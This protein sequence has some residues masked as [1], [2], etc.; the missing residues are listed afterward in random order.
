MKK[1]VLISCFNWYDARLKPVRDI[2]AERGYKVS[3]LIADFDHIKKELVYPRSDECTYLHVPDYRSNL[4]VAR[5]ISHISFAKQCRRFIYEHSP[6]IIYCQV[7]PNKAADYCACYKRENPDVRLIVDIIDLWP[8]SMPVGMLGSTPPAKI[9][10]NWRNEAIK[11]A[12]LVITECGMYQNKLKKHLVGKQYGTLY[13][14]RNQ[15]E[16]ERNAVLGHLRSVRDSTCREDISIGYVGSINNIIDIEEI[17][18][19]ISGLKAGGFRVSMH[20]IGDGKSRREF[21]SSMKEAGAD[22]KYYG[23]VFDET[24]KAKILGRCDFALNIMKRGLSVALT[25]KSVDYLSKGVPV[26]NNIKWDTWS[27]V[28]R[29]KIGINYTGDPAALVRDIRSSDL[30][31]LS[32][33]AYKCYTE[34]FT[35]EAFTESVHRELSKLGI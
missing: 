25:I 14:F 3:V 9:W 33:N 5:I 31:Q 6:D 7:P 13:L 15:S 11:A 30:N 32:A 34:M 26:I 1:A 12:D 23:K 10:M 2:L 18:N 28:E 4:S 16:S 24:A 8:E 27:L 17:K 29:K 22:V 35:E 21:L 19:I 20:I